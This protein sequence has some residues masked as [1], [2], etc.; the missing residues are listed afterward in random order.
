M[1]KKIKFE[2]ALS[3]LERVIAK[4]ESPDTPLDEAMKLYEK[5]VSLVRICTERLE[6]AEQ[7]IFLLQNNNGTLSETEVGDEIQ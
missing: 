7:R 5:G 4:L 6:S 1:E 3:E 2:T